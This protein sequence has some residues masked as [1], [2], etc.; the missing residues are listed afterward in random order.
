M[1]DYSRIIPASETTLALTGLTT[2]LADGQ[3][4]ASAGIDLNF[5]GDS[6]QA[7]ITDVLFGGYVQVGASGVDGTLGLYVSVSL[8]GG[9]TYSGGVSGT[10]GED[11][12]LDLTS[13]A[14]TIV[15]RFYT[16]TNGAVIEFPVYS[17]KRAV[18]CVPDAFALVIDNA[19]GASLAADTNHALYYKIQYHASL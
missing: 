10:A 7:A 12:T 4:W 15:D 3:Q 14:L 5:A 18:G 9:T 17:L 19:T 11:N 8:D 16:A 1:T 6:P 2:T 13:G